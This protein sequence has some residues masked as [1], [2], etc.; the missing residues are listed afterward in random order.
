MRSKTYCVNITPIPWKAVTRKHLS[1]ESQGGDIIA[2]GLHI[3]QQHNDEPLFSTPIQLKIKFY[4][5]ISTNHQNHKPKSKHHVT[6]PFLESLYKFVI[7]VM[8]DIVITDERII[9]SL[10]LEKVYD[11]NPR[12]EIVITEVD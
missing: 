7:D 3:A 9:C 4:M 11:K 12:T 1:Y 10:T 6:I 8:K 5:P 2:F